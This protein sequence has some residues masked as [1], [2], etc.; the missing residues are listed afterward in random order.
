MNARTQLSHSTAL[1]KTVTKVHG[2][3]RTDNSNCICILY[4]ERCAAEANEL[5]TLQKNCIK[6]NKPNNRCAVR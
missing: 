5:Q 1:V 4:Y 2:R 3:R 6:L